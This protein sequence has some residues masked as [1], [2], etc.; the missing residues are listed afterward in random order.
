MWHRKAQQISPIIKKS[1]LVHS[2][3]KPLGSLA[4]VKWQ[5]KPK[6]HASQSESLVNEHLG[7]DAKQ[8]NS[9]S[10]S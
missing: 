1:L 3:C 5:I 8:I 4:T 10:I 2:K 9:Q 6:P 7:R